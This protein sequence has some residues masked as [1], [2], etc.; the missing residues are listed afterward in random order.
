MESSI[1]KAMC[2]AITQSPA[3]YHL[4]CHSSVLQTASQSHEFNTQKKCLPARSSAWCPQG[5]FR[6]TSQNQIHE[7]KNLFVMGRCRWHGTSVFNVHVQLTTF[8]LF[9]YVNVQQTPWDGGPGITE[10]RRKLYFL[11]CV[12]EAT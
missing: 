3:A 4:R 7:S 6:V 2:R 10:D 5:T 8:L 1:I 9:E 11:L 12:P